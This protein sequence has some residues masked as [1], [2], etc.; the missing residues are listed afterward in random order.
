MFPRG[1]VIIIIL[2]KFP[3]LCIQVA[4]IVV[5]CKIYGVSQD[6]REL[7]IKLVWSLLDVIRVVLDLRDS[8]SFT[9]PLCHV[10]ARR[11]YLQAML[12]STLI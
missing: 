8:L 6:F 10:T 11:I 4:N 5:S 7:F 2:I 1:L 12:A 3:L 9:P